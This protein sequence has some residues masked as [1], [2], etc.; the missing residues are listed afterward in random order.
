MAKTKYHPNCD[1]RN[2]N[3]AILQIHIEYRKVF[4]GLI[5]T[6]LLEK[7]QVLELPQNLFSQY[8]NKPRNRSIGYCCRN[9]ANT[10]TATATAVAVG[11]LIHGNSS[12]IWSRIGYAFVIGYN[13]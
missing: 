10:A 7:S 4:S 9:E 2:T 13:K 3:I 1:E 5:F 6:E 12:A 11:R 8:F